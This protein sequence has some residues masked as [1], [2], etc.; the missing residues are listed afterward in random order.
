LDGVELCKNGKNIWKE[1]GEMKGKN[2]SGLK[3]VDVRDSKETAGRNVLH[4]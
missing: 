1:T 3:D 2:I 4:W